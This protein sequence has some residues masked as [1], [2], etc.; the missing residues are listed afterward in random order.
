MIRIPKDFKEFLQLLNENDVPYLLVGGYAVGIYG[1]PRA[2]G[3]MDIWIAIDPESSEKIVTVLQSFGF[4]TPEIEPE[5]FQQPDKIIRMGHPP[6]R[7]EVHTSITGVNFERAYSNREI[8]EIDGIPIK[9]IG[10]EDLKNNKKA[11]G[12]FK[13]LDDLENLTN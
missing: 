7:I 3:D 5:L 4:D 12:R 11:T 10:L 1:Y 13:D 6:M 9:V 8:Q 2:T